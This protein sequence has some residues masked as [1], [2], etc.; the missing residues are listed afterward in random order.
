M[1]QIDFILLGIFVLLLVLVIGKG[2]TATDNLLV[3][4]F[5]IGCVDFTPYRGYPTYDIG[6][7]CIFGSLFKSLIIYFNGI[8]AN[9]IRLRQHNG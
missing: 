1:E 3:E 4:G 8:N 2:I 5:G 7:N 6:I 9:F